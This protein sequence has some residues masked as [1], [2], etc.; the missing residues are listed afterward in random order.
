VVYEREIARA[1]RLLRTAKHAIALTGAGISTPSGIPDFRSPG[2][3]LWE[4]D[5]AMDVIS[6]R[7]F[8]RHPERFYEWMRP[9]LGAKVAAEPNPAHVALA[10]LEQH[11]IVRAVITQNIDDLHRRAGSQ[12]VLEMHGTLHTVTCQKC[13]RQTP[14]D[15]L[16]PG[17]LETG[18]MP[19]CPHCNGVVKP[20][21]VFFGELLPEDTVAA[22]R[23]H[24]N[25]ADVMLVAGSS[26]EVT[27]VSQLPMGIIDS[28]GRVIVV[29]YTP[30]YIDPWASVVIHDDVAWVLPRIAE[31]CVEGAKTDADNTDVTDS[32]GSEGMS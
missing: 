9:L 16:L 20:D 28:G 8:R 14:S 22:S 23:W 1:A 4:K 10:E 31:A 32:H 29:N 12:E 26:L 6:L 3:G 25:Q 30:T 17:Y 21:I 19:R 18:E 27:P 13:G 2:D 7:V 24:V 15:D 5:N 11:G